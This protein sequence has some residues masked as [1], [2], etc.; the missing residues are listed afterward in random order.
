MQR[1]TPEQ[2]IERLEKEVDYLT[3]FIKNTLY[4][5]YDLS[6]VV[7]Q[8]MPSTPQNQEVINHIRAVTDAAETSGLKDDV[9]H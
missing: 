8:T 5:L 2:R 3:G 7:E 9:D 4:R 6:L 1:G